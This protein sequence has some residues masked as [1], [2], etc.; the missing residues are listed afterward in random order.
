MKWLLHKNLIIWQQHKV[1]KNGVLFADLL[2]LS[3]ASESS[4]LLLLKII[5]WVTQAFSCEN[6]GEEIVAT[7]L[8][9]N[10]PIPIKLIILE[11]YIPFVT[12]LLLLENHPF[13]IFAQIDKIYMQ[14]YPLL[15]YV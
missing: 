2:D 11:M 13:D 5:S 8:V 10:L 15:N 7:V 14:E 6:G 9:A 3:M 12:V 4:F 1:F